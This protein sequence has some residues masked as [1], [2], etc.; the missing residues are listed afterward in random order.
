MAKANSA[1]QE[2]QDESL[3]PGFGGLRPGIYK[4]SE[5][6][7]AEDLMNQL[8]AKI[9]LLDAMLEFIGPGGDDLDQM[10]DERRSNYLWGCQTLARE[11][12]DLSNRLW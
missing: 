3:L 2:T 5:N 9:V 11:C 7:T 10:D 1:L 6:A 12:K 8:H 4:L